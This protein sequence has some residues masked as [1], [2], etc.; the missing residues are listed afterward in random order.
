MLLVGDLF[1]LQVGIYMEETGLE[2]ILSN[3]SCVSR[4]LLRKTTENVGIS[5]LMDV[6]L[7]AQP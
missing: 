7:C 2:R 5:G 6:V 3:S 4:E 1:E